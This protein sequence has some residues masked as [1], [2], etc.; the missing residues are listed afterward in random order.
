ML[1]EISGTFVK[2]AFSDQVDI[3]LKRHS[4]NRPAARFNRL[5]QDA[6]YLSVDQTSARVAIKKY[7]K[8][9]DA[10]RVLISYQVQSCQV[11][12]L[13]HTDAEELRLLASQDWQQT[14][15]TGNEP[16]SWQVADTLRQSGVVGLIDQSRRNPSLHHV[17]LLKWNEAGA[18]D[19]T[20]IGDPTSISL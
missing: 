2:I 10:A 20:M 18:P 8:A 13:R 9:A 14:L 12:D 11:I 1:T 17:T 19:V 7:V 15:A 16:T 3:L 5:G 6:L 4:A